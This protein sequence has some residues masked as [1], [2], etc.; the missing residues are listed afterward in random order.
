MVL[1]SIV[2]FC[3]SSAG[4]SPVYYKKSY[5]LGILLA[6]K[7]ISLVYGGARVGLMGAVADGA[8][9]KGGQVIG[10]I[11]EFLLIKEVAHKG[12]SELKIVQ[13]MHERKSAMN[14]LSDGVIVLPGGFGT[15]DE[16]FEMLTWG[17]L[18]L[19]QKPIGIYNMDGF[20]N[21][22]IS[23]ISNLVNNGF[24]KKENRNMLLVD[25]ETEGLLFQMETFKSIA[26]TKWI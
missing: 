21:D 3:G 26:L 25:E 24:L 18:G 2:I 5:E 11:P 17:Q 22:L 19:H 14:E 1:K 12:L 16:L 15:L 6:E 7:G 13:S 10:V 23:F 9:S 20:Y 4:N 8:I